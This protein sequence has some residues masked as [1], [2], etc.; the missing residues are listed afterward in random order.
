MGKTFG[1]HCVKASHITEPNRTELASSAQFSRS[2]V[3]G[4][5]YA[6]ATPSPSD[7]ITKQDSESMYSKC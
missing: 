2:D 7:N 4:S 3:D 6:I 1:D 5:L